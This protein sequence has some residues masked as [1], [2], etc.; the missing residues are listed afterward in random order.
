[1]YEYLHISKALISS[2]IA[3]HLLHH[4][5]WT[6]SLL[7]LPSLYCHLPAWFQFR[8]LLAFIFKNHGSES[9]F[10]QTHFYICLCLITAHGSLFQYLTSRLH[11]LSTSRPFFAL[12]CLPPAFSPLAIP[13][14]FVTHQNQYVPKR[15]NAFSIN[16]IGPSVF[17]MM[18]EKER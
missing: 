4:I 15:Q 13:T 7:M 17:L 2:M 9:Y 1:M 6:H 3:H 16:V 12:Q 18:K 8:S 14:D 10:V 5:L 11:C